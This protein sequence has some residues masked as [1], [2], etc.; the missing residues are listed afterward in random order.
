MHIRF[1]FLSIFFLV[2]LSMAAQ[3]NFNQFDDDGKRHG[4]WQK[5]YENSDQIRYEGNFQHGKEIGIFKFYCEDCKSVPSLIKT[6]NDI[7]N[8]AQVVYYSKSG[9]I[10][11]EGKMEGK[12]R[13]GEWLYYHKKGKG[14][15][16]KEFY[17]DGNL[18]GTKTVYYLNHKIAEKLNYNNGEKEGVNNYYSPQGVI[19]K[20]LLY[21][22]DELHGPAVYYDAYGNVTLKGNY[23][24]GRKD[25]VWQHYKEGD[26]V[27]EEKYPKQNN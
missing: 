7:D 23:K 25:G 4:Q 3:D 6:F 8:T 17:V 22:N 18:H 1:I 14:I 20:K 12:N 13:I 24:N 15:M 5:T 27:K 9:R 10:L 21:K 26:L 11:S 19:L 2:S 16:T